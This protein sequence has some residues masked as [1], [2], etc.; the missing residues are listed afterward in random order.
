MTSISVNPLRLLIISTPK[1]H[2][3]NSEKKICLHIIMDCGALLCLF[4]NLIT[5][6]GKFIQFSATYVVNEAVQC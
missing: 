1:S 3:T 2:I 4:H 6:C 5:I